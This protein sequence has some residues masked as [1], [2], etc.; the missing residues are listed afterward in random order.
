MKKHLGLTKVT[1]DSSAVIP[2]LFFDYKVVTVD[3]ETVTMN[4]KC[5]YVYDEQCAMLFGL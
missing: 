5:A 2:E 4:G 1:E 3:E